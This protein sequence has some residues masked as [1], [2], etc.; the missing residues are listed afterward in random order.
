MNRDQISL[1]DVMDEPE[2]DPIFDTEGFDAAENASTQKFLEIREFVANNRSIM[3]IIQNES[4]N[5]IPLTGI[6]ISF[7]FC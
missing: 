6:I 3:Q 7:L 2:Q 4:F 5:P 1:R